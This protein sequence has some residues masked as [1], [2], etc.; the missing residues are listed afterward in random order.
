VSA[1]HSADSAHGGDAVTVIQLGEN[2]GH[3]RE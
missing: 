2:S 1:F 3:R